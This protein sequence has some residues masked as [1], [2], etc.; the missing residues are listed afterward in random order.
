MTSRNVSDESNRAPWERVFVGETIRLRT[1][2]GMT[3]RDL[4]KVLR[5][6]FELP[7]HQQTVQRI[8][9]GERPVRLNE[10]FAIA[11]VLDS[12][13][14]QMT[15]Q[16]QTAEAMQSRI[17]WTTARMDETVFALER[18]VGNLDSVIIG[19][20]NELREDWQG[21]LDAAGDEPDER[22]RDEVRHLEWRLDRLFMG[23][24]MVLERPEE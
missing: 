20:R 6:R 10:A 8:E 4:S 3:Q 23:V 15:Q 19:L 9:D 16:G 7:F 18:A 2:A 22:L 21:Y 1:A 13:V 17:D 5:E 11:S 24:T 12:T 14:E